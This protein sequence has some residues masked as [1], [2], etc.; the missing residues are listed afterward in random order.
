MTTKQIARLRAQNRRLRLSN[1]ALRAVVTDVR[2][3]FVCTDPDGTWGVDDDGSITGS[4]T[5]GHPPTANTEIEVFLAPGRE[6][7]SGNWES[8]WRCRAVRALNRTED[9]RTARS[10]KPRT[11]KVTDDG[12]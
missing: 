10:T 12:K 2:N 5:L 9:F 3:D 11:T 7:H 6:P 1:N 8:C 4:F